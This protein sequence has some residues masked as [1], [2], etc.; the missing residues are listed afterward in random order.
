M[1]GVFASATRHNWYTRQSF[2]VRPNMGH[3]LLRNQ[4][5]GIENFCDLSSNVARQSH[6]EFFHDFQNF[7]KSVD[8]NVS[9]LFFRKQNVIYQHDSMN[10]I[11]VYS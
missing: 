5:F 6:H 2:I 4:K 3:D 10:P 1:S 11:K 8:D 7:Y 9:N